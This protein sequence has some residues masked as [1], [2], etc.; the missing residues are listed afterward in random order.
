MFQHTLYDRIAE[1]QKTDSELADLLNN[2]QNI[3]LTKI[4]DLYCEEFQNCKNPVFHN[5]FEEKTLLLFMTFCI[6]DLNRP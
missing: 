2:T 3:E 4:N 6:Q 5:L 1:A